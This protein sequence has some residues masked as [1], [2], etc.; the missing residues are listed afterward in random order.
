MRKMP[1]NEHLDF[2]VYHQVLTGVAYYHQ[3]QSG[4]LRISGR[5]RV[6]FL[7]RQTTND[8]TRLK[9]D[10]SI[11]T[12]LISPTARLLDVIRLIVDG[13]H[14]IALTLPNRGNDT[15][16]FLK[17]RIFF[18]DQV[19]VLDESTEVCQFDLEGP[20]I[21][22]FLQNLGLDRLPI[23]DQVLDWELSGVKVKLVG[24]PGLA[25]L[26]L[27]IVAPEWTSGTLQDVL[28]SNGVAALDQPTYHVCRVEAGMPFS[29]AE[30]TG[31]FTPL[32]AGLQAYV[33]DDKGCYTGQEVI[34]RQINYDKIT[35]RLVGLKMT[36]ESQPATRIWADGKS[37]GKITSTAKSPRFGQIALAIIKRP[38]DRV[39]TSLMLSDAADSNG[40][41]ATVV[42]IPFV[43][44][45]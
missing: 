9:P 36:S 17:N 15:V 10:R 2:S 11:V 12:V 13:E 27:R 8:L 41:Q 1:D 18:M 33:A 38:F 4:C 6:D 5:D 37:V 3:K 42:D 44:A 23:L 20:K 31:D 45:S 25:G 7:H 22:N 16:S 35:Q 40:T 14:L 19:Q 21:A 24:Q 29:G 28:Q 39:G 30:L 32:E 43:K 26:S 34:A